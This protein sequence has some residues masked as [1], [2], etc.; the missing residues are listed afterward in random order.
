MLRSFRYPRAAEHA[1]AKARAV[2]L[3]PEELP[4][5]LDGPSAPRRGER[6]AA[7][8]VAAAVGEKGDRIEPPHDVS[9]SRA[10]L[11]RVQIG[12]V[13]AADEIVDLLPPDA[14]RL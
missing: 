11:R 14:V 8:A 12:R 10:D 2:L 5:D 3:R 4:A 1:A 7:K 13:R 9:H 6:P